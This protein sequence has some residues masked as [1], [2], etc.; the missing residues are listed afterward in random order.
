MRLFF[1][2]EKG[3]EMLNF[4]IRVRN[5]AFW[6]G[7]ASVIVAAVYQILGLCGVTPAVSQS[8]VINIISLLLTVLAGLGVVVDPTTDGI[9]D[10]KRVLARGRMDYDGEVT[11]MGA[12]SEED[13]EEV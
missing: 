8:D 4:K 3:E 10:S 11:A 12:G 6:A 9:A 13:T 5:K 1:I 7:T 2:T